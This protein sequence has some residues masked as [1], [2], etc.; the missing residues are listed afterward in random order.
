[1]MTTEMDE[2]LATAVGLTRD[3]WSREAQAAREVAAQRGML[4]REEKLKWLD[5]H[6]LQALQR[7]LLGDDESRQ[8]RRRAKAMLR[9]VALAAAD[10]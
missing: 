5:V 2:R 4:L 3:A 10:A 6:D 9:T 1:M 8:A 7:H